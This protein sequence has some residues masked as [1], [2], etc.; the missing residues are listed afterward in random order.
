MHALKAS[1]VNEMFKLALRRKSLF[2]L[3]LCLLVPVG[4]ALT[5]DRVQAGYGLAFVGAGDLPMRVLWL[6]TSFLLPLIAF[7]TAVDLFTGEA[8]AGTLKTALTRPVDRF[9]LYAAKI[10][11]IFLS[12]CL[13]TAVGLLFSLIS[14][15]LLQGREDWAAGI[16]PTATAFAA[17]VLPMTVLGAMA[18]FV[19][20]LFKNTTGALAVLIVLYA[21]LKLS[22]LL[23]PAVSAYLPVHYTDWHLLWTD[24]PTA[25]PR[26]TGIFALLAAWGLIFFTA[27]SVLFDKKEV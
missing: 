12:V 20:Q 5:L 26:L 1:L 25:W 6:F 3:A 13:Y 19:A 7:M 14:A 16:L 8:E 17:S 9:R 15:L 22:V 24:G 23:V 11:A 10:G 18:G 2:F 27:G 21:L 4:A